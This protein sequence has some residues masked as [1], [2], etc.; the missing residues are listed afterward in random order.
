V[1]EK[2]VLRLTTDEDQMVKATIA[3]LEAAE[4]CILR[5]KETIT[6][7]G[8]PVIAG[9]C[10]AAHTIIDNLKKEFESGGWKEL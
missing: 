7:L 3:H 9:E 8:K 4:V 6:F 10:S 5:A 2:G 1:Y